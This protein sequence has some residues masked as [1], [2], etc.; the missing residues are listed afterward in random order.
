MALVQ[1]AWF[2]LIFI[3]VF[4]TLCVVRLDRDTKWLWHL[5]FIPIWILD[6]VAITSLIVLS[7]MHFKSGQNPY[8]EFTIGKW[9]KIWLLYL[10]IL[11]LIFLLTLC[12]KL[13]GLTDA[14]YLE[15]FIPLWFLLVSIGVDAIM[16][17][18]K[19]ARAQTHRD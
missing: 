16:A 14:S 17:T 3:T 12:A 4:L 19:S 18:V 2:F 7:I 6:A 8:P 5:V 11:K 10:Y 9:R 15:V 13:D 1:R